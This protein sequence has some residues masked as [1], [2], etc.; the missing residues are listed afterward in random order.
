MLEVAV[1]LEEAIDQL[2][3]LRPIECPLRPPDELHM[4]LFQLHL[5]RIGAIIDDIRKAVDCYNY[6]ISWTNPSL[7]TLSMVIFVYVCV[8]FNTEYIARYGRN[9]MFWSYHRF[10]S[11][12]S[13]FSQPFFCLIIYML[14]L[15]W[16][17]SQG[18]LKNRFLRKEQ[19]AYREVGLRGR[20]SLRAISF[21]TLFV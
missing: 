17:R 19:D 13:Y 11:H 3:G 2:F 21:P 10:P 4:Q 8:T 1:C 9:G 7:T 18:N 14:Y 15:A 20:S 5:A 12:A 6:L 16:I